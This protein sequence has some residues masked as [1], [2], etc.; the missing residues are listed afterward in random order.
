VSLRDAVM[1]LGAGPIGRPE[2]Q[3][4]RLRLSMARCKAVACDWLHRLRQNDPLRVGGPFEG[5]MVA[6]TLLKDANYSLSLLIEEIDH[7]PPCNRSP[8]SGS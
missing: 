2:D 7:L 1:I 8:L 6:R 5:V 3:A 4:F